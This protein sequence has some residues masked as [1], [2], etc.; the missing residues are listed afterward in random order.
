MTL[1][2]EVIQ[3]IV[4]HCGVP[5]TSRQIR[6][7]FAISDTPGYPKTRARIKLAMREEAIT[8]GIAIGSDHRG[9]FVLATPDDFFNYMTN[10]DNRMDGIRERQHLCRKAWDQSKRLQGGGDGG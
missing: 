2:E 4:E 1:E 3:F 9:Y 8:M 7:R 6:E 5:V 10:L